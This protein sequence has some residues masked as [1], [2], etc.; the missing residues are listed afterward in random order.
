MSSKIKECICL[1]EKL[2]TRIKTGEKSSNCSS[3]FSKSNTNTLNQSAKSQKEDN[4]ENILKDE[5]L[6]KL[7][8]NSNVSHS[9]K[10]KS[11]NEE[12]QTKEVSGKEEKQKNADQT[13]RNS[14]NK[15]KDGKNKIQDSATPQEKKDSKKNKDYVPNP[16][17]DWFS[18]ITNDEKQLFQRLELR[19]GEVK[20]VKPLENSAKLYITSIDFGEY[21]RTVLTGL[22][23][24]IPLEK[25]IGKVVVF[26]NLKH[27]KMAGILSEGMITTAQGDGKC[28]LL[29]PEETTPLGSR[30][31]LE[32]EDV[33]SETKDSE[34]DFEIL[35]EF[36]KHFHTN[37]S[38]S[39]CYKNISLTA[40]GVPLLKNSFENVSIS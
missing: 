19:V 40:N 21:S 15:E 34:V 9:Q 37:S 26:T 14:K 36:L 38:G 24:A 17:K 33:S 8:L 29:R 18:S 35:C 39:P 1:V 20:S 10:N 6:E 7:N 28:E 12:A 27:R 32:N 11:S 16:D 25:M 13:D 31:L 5:Y 3:I 2:I 30:I 23:K 4:S 22:Q